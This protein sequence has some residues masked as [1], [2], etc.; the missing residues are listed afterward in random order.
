[1]MNVNI[2]KENIEYE[3]PMICGLLDSLFWEFMKL[4][5]K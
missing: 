3:Y 4:T 2:D 5:H 1:M